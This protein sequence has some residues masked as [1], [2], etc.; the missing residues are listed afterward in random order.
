MT[1]SENY[2]ESL[3]VNLLN[4]MITKD[5]KDAAEKSIP[6]F[7]KGGTKTFPEYILVL[8]R[9]RR[10]L[11]KVV[12]KENTLENRLKYN[13]LTSQIK[14]NIKNY[15]Q[16]KWEGFIEGLGG[17]PVSSRPFWNEIN[18]IKNP[19][20]SSGIPN[21][22]VDDIEYKSDPEKINLFSSIF[23]ETFSDQ[24]ATNVF[25]D[26]NFKEVNNLVQ[27]FNFS[28]TNI[29]FFSSSELIKVLNRL[30][31]NSSPGCDG[32]E[33]IFL[34]RLPFEYSK[35]VLLKLFNLC[36]KEGI[37]DDWK[38]GS[39]TM[40]PKKTLKSKDPGDYRPISLTS[41][42]G[43]AC[44][45]LVKTR[46]YGF[47]E[48]KNL[49]VKQQSGFRNKRGT[50]DNLFFFTQKISESLSKGKKVFWIFLISQ[51]LLIRYGMQD[52]FLN[53][54]GWVSQGI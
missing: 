14:L 22:K 9:E 31:I 10:T 45:R 54:I 17:Y 33:N 34:K 23:N 38:V 50:S 47:L 35:N 30:K 40:I 24:V 4:S 25:D 7:K 36:L 48:K 42:L 6:K 43:K 39:I 5:I 1:Y 27:K 8:I 12:K 44:E 41:C 26:N 3:D 37:P 52:F 28:E 16:K 20:Q 11:R 18:K 51:R 2:L 29:E 53:W 15:R 21:L 49:L 32:I 19:K 13:I 46:L